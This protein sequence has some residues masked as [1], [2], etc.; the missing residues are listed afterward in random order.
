MLA[1]PLFADQVHNA[2]IGAHRRTTIIVRPQ[3]LTV[4]SIATALDELLY[5]PSYM[6][7]AKHISRLMKMKPEAGRNKFVEW[8]EFAAANK[9]LHRIFNLPGNDIGA[10]E[11]YCLDC[12][13]LLSVAVATVSALVWMLLS[14]MIQMLMVEGIFCVKIKTL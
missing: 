4:K 12:I 1:I 5:N 2:Q 3:Q 13:I 7:N 11:Y 10:V 8:L 14:A 9:N 6:E